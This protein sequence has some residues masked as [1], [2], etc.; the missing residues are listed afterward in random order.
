MD[1]IETFE[2][3]DILIDLGAVSKETKGALQGEIEQVDPFRPR[4]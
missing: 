1:H 3:E 2:D 4:D